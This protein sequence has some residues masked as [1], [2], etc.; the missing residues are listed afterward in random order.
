MLQIFKPDELMA[1]VVGNEEYDW[2]ALEL[3]CEYKNGYNSG[4]QTV[5][6]FIYNEKIVVRHVHTDY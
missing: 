6:T 4:D 3:H 1:V 5:S 2:Q